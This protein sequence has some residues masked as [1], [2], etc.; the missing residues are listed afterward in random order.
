MFRYIVDAQNGGAIVGG[1]GGGGQRGGQSFAGLIATTGC[2]QKTFS[3]EADHD[4]KSGGGDLVE[5]LQQFKIL[6]DGFSKSESRINH[7]LLTR[8]TQCLGA[9]GKLQKFF[10]H[11]A[12]D[13]VVLRRGNI[14]IAVLILIGGAQAM[15]E[16]KT[17]AVRGDHA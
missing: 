4:W 10:K 9:L 8:H 6:R 14:L 7:D 17:R 1:D 11:I 12:R 2:A 3:T 13:I 16:N 15:H 5:V